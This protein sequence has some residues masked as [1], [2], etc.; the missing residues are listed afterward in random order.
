MTKRSII[1][2]FCFIFFIFC[3]QYL[4]SQGIEKTYKVTCLSFYNLENLYDTLD[5]PN[6][7]DDDFTP[8]GKNNW[9]T[10]RYQLKLDH[11]AS[12]I[13]QIGNEIVQGGPVL[14]GLAEVENQN[15]LNDLVA[16]PSL[17]AADYGIVHY[18]SPDQRGIDVALIYQKKNFTVTNSKPVTLKIEGQTDFASRD[19]L[20]VSGLLD[21]ELVY[22]IVNHWPSRR[23]GEKK[24]APLR[25]A[26]A[27][28]TKTIVDSIQ[29]IDSM[30][31]IIIMGDFN[32]DPVNTSLVKYLG[33][34]SEVAGTGSKDLYN[35][36]YNLYKKEGLGTL[37]YRDSWDLFDQFILT[38]SL[39]GEDKATWKFFKARIFNKNFLAQKEGSFAGY[40]FRTYIGSSY[41]GGYSDHFPSY[42]FL[43]KEK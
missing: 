28:L 36:M 7:N 10:Q 4:F 26:A 32:D 40:P 16:Q 9:N 11:I 2:I 39:I 27:M 33:T 20:V 24:S 14:M 17:K 5:D 15:V 42:I 25:N 18:D 19:Q 34:K 13:A 23:G 35:P 6:K 8:T 1:F 37:A 22:I 41:Q 43:V 21:G 3:C 12:V 31:R 29:K 38:G 30:A